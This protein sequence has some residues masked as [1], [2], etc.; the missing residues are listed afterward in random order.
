MVLAL[1]RVRASIW[2]QRCDVAAIPDQ[3]RCE[4]VSALR[5]P[6]SNATLGFLRS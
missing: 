2:P 1:A 4:A 6:V 3:K 5:K